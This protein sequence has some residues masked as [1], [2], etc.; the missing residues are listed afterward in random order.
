MSLPCRLEYIVKLLLQGRGF[1]QWPVRILLM[2]EN[3]IFKYGFRD[4]QE[5]RY[6]DIHFCAFC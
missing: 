5:V 2:A 1:S 3:D 6:L 4:S